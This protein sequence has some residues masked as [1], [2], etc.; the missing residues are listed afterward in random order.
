VG[1]EAGTQD[2]RRF[3]RVLNNIRNLRLYDFE[4]AAYA[5]FATPA[6]KTTKY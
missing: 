1:E 4:S 2:W 5:N 6:A 3:Q